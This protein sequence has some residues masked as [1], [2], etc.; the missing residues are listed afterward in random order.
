MKPGVADSLG[1]LHPLGA[2]HRRRP[3]QALS[4]YS[5]L[6]WG[7]SSFVAK[8]SDLAMGLWVFEPSMICVFFQFSCVANFRFDVWRS[9]LLRPPPPEVK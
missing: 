1:L 3:V 8:G 7:F 9:A 5:V 4:K 2:R 6:G